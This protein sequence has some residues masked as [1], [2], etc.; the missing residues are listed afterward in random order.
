MQTYDDRLSFRDFLYKVVA[1]FMNNSGELTLEET[2]D[3]NSS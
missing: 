1:D 2:M 3:I